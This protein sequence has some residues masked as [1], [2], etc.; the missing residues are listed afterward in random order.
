MLVNL[1]AMEFSVEA[2]VHSVFPGMVVGLALG[3]IEGI[4][5][6]AGVVAAGAAAALTVVTKQAAAEAGTAVE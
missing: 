2:L 5:P 4:V 3:G 6:G 1:R